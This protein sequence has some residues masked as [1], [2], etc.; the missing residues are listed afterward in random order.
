M[1]WCTFMAF[2]ARLY[3]I[4]VILFQKHKFRGN[5]KTFFN[6]LKCR[7][8]SSHILF[9]S[10]GVTDDKGEKSCQEK[11]YH[12]ERWKLN[13]ARRFFNN[14]EGTNSEWVL[15]NSENEGIKL[16][17][18]IISV[19][20]ENRAQGPSSSDYQHT[21]T[22]TENANMVLWTKTMGK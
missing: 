8:W 3:T 13:I 2:F 5:Y 4:S 1:I 18:G 10:L 11:S 16:F 22:R 12:K 6:L 15:K 19:I 17:R 20:T 7:S 14:I 9:I 21:E